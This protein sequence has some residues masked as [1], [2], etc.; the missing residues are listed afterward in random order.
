MAPPTRKFTKPESDTPYFDG[1]GIITGNY[2]VGRL[3]MMG[4]R[5]A[6]ARSVQVAA[7]FI[8]KLHVAI[9]EAPR[10]ALDTIIPTIDGAYIVGRTKLA[11]LDHMG[12][13]IRALARSFV[14]ANNNYRKFIVRG[15]L[16]YGP[17]ALGSSMIDASE[18]L[19]EKRNAGYRDSILVGMPV[20]Q[21]C[22]VEEQAPPFGVRVHTSARTFSPDGS[23]PLNSTYWRWWRL[24]DDPHND[25]PLAAKLKVAVVNYF[26]FMREHEVELEYPRLAID[27]HE[28][29][30]NE[31]FASA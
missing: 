22:E 6:M 9:L 7:N 5:A 13:S 16:A 23:T 4:A 2:Y 27:K 19:S 25:K 3:D 14:A 18:C 29:L 20:V 8:G 21:A 31:Y 12:A 30:A 24:K 26:R 28:Q 11:V 10:N 17:V 15:G 1:S